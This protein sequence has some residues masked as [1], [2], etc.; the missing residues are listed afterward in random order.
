MTDGARRS[1][2]NRRDRRRD[3]RSTCCGRSRGRRLEPHRRARRRR[4]RR[5]RPTLAATPAAAADRRRRRV[6][7]DCRRRVVAVRVARRRRHPRR[8]GRRSTLVTSATLSPD[9]VAELAAACREAGRTF[10]DMPVTGGRA[11]A[12]GGALVML[13]G[14]E[15]TDL[16]AIGDVLDA[17]SSR[18]ATSAPSAAGRGSSSCSTPCRP[19]HLVGFGEAMATGALPSVSTPATS[20]A[21]LVDR[22]GGPVTKMAWAADQQLPERANFALAWALKDLRYAAAMAGD[23]PAP[24]LDVA[25]R[26]P[27]R[28][29]GAGLGE[30]D[31]TVANARADSALT[32]APSSLSRFAVDGDRSGHQGLDLGARASVP[33][34]AGSTRR[35][36]RST[37]W[38]G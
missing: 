21:A 26:P 17:I 1:G 31:W 34:S 8:L 7:G 15:A 13:A 23:V 33:A 10:L 12:E 2:R 36:S 30:R 20:D 35:R 27:R 24:M 25:G 37:T 6:R 9:W 3:G 28:R 32:A 11:G 29:S 22:L 19:L 16:A 38:R 4:R 5:R 14:G 18:F